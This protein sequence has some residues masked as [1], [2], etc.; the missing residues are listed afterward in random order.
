MFQFSQA[1]PSIEATASGDILKNLMFQTQIM[2]DT[3]SVMSHL[4]KMRGEV[5][6][7]LGTALQNATEQE[8]EATRSSGIGSIVGA[9]GQTVFGAGGMIG[10]ATIGKSQLNTVNEQLENVN[11]WDEAVKGP[12][13]HGVFG[14]ME[15]NAVAL[16]VM[17]RP[18]VVQ[19]PRVAGLRNVNPKTE[20]LNDE[21]ANVLEVA[22]GQ[23]DALNDKDPV[24]VLKKNISSSKKSLEKEQSSIENRRARFS[25]KMN[26]FSRVVSDMSQG[27]GQLAAA[28]HTTLKAQEQNTQQQMTNANEILQNVMD[29]SNQLV[30]TQDDARG[31]TLQTLAAFA[32]ANEVRA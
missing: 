11:K 20:L 14:D 25:E 8:A 2:Q 9:S 19:D 24:E 13:G 32:R 16:G 28:T 31:T 15:D 23:G 30:R 4:A 18:P 10:E 22:K 26:M 27:G 21:H 5:N 6:L 1:T 29:T 7:A 3:L 12:A 17:E